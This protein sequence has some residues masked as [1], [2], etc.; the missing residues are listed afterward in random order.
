MKDD[1][2]ISPQNERL[3]SW[4]KLQKDGN[5]RRERGEFVLEGRRL[6]QAALASGLVKTFLYADKLAPDDPLI[7]D[8][9]A[10]G[11]EV[12]MVSLVAFRKL[13][14][15]PS[16]QGIACVART[17]GIKTATLFAN[18][19]L[20]V[21]ACGVQEPGNLGTMVRS[22]AAAGAT[23]LVALPPSADLFH[24]RAV[25]ASAGAVLTQGTVRMG[26]DEFVAAAERA[27]L[28]ILSA[29]PRGGVDYRA[30]DYSRPVAIALGSE[31]HGIPE[32]VASASSGTTIPMPGGTE[33][34]NAAAAAALLVFEA[35]RPR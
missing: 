16:P 13:A 4:V 25:R 12:I 35:I 10:R 15:V 32:S 8:A 5:E 31:A 21:V 26:V 14:D 2:I 6:V 30:A 18:D 24:P 7:A 20:L 1:R 19:A 33:S 29:V 23:G 11:I 22:A 27:G 3:K 9:R 28:R 34:L 17:P